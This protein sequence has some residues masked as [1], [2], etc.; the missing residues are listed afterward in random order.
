M[1]I[2]KKNYL[3][4]V[5][6]LISK[7]NSKVKDIL[8]DVIMMCESKKKDSTIRKDDKGNITHVFCYYHKVWE[9]INKIEYGSK[10]SSHS[11]LNT[12][13]KVGVNQWTK[14]QAQFKKAKNDLLD[15][16]SSGDIK[17]Q[18]IQN[19]LKTL[20]KNKDRIVP[21]HKEIIKAQE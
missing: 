21:R 7:K 3:E 19:H 15:K 9:M 5:A 2:V 14:Q 4:I 8:A 18:E 13:C 17:P 12:M 1:I 20:E 11:G 10:A 6:F 16:V